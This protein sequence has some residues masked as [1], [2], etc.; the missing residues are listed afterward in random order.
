MK[1]RSAS[2]IALSAALCLMSSAALAQFVN[3]RPVQRA[4]D[5]HLAMLMSR[6]YDKLDQ[7]ADEARAKNSTTSDGQSLLSAI[8]DGVAGCACG[9]QLNEDLWVVRKQRLEEWNARKPGSVTA[10]L[11]MAAFPMKYG[12]MA[13]GS[14]Y[15]NTVS[16]DAWKIFR[17]RVDEGRKSLEALDAKIKEDAGW[18]EMMLA[19]AISQGWPRE[20]YDALF[21][22]GVA[23]HPHYLPLYFSRAQYYSPRWH[24]SPE[25]FQ[26]VVDDSV[27]RTR[28]TLG[29]TLY[30]RIHWGF[31]D[32]YMFQRQQADWPRMKA[33]FEHMMKDYP[34]PWNLNNFGKFACLADDFGTLK[35]LLPKIGNNPILMG[36]EDNMDFYNFCRSLAEKGKP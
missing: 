34:D 11:S 33:G 30:A 7:A 1:A 6:A 21:E 17:D 14:G 23:K 29:E 28:S 15:A 22:K 25:E 18:F 3:P 12:W 32:P 2:R 16:Q 20:R 13:R 4:T 26:R 31:Q 35:Q 27:A 5:E 24:G 8:Y 10:R 36:W 9:N 19:V